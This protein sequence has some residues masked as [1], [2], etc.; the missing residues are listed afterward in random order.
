MR[1]TMKF[2]GTSVGTPQRI[3][4]VAGLVAASIQEGNQVA[5]VVS[6]MSGATNQLVKWV[7]EIA[8]LHDP[9]EYDVVVATG[10][11][12]TIAFLNLVPY[13][14]PVVFMGLHVFVSFVQAFIFTVLA[15]AYVGGAV[16]HHHDAVHE[17]EHMAV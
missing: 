9:R 10:E 2:G 1:L 11:Q 8:P 16:A 12:V 14:I 17:S 13:G 4:D 3:R 7:N 15:M 5:V 6:A